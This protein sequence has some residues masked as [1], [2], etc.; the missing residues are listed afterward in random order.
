VDERARTRVSKFLSFVLRHRPDSIGLELDDAGWVDVETLLRESQASGT[1]ITRAELEEVVATS[2]KRR[3]ALSED[4]LRIRAS[5]GH[6]VEVELG[7]EP[8][9][10]PEQLF[11]GTV[12]SAL[13]SI[14]AQGLVRMARHHVH[15]SS[16]RATATNVGQRRGAPIILTVRAG[17]MHRAGF[18]FYVSANGVW[19]TEHVPPE[20]LD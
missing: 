17:R 16:D 5:Q 18:V 19:L 7:Y 12:A 10:P 3:F 6:S 1:T 4:G 13:E 20:F 14:R 15:L 9:P 8:A 11:H 2:P